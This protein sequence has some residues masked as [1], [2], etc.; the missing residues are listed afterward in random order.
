VSAANALMVA[1]PP[2][3]FLPVVLNAI[4]FLLKSKSLI[5]TEAGVI[6]DVDT[7]TEN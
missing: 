1:I 6:F 5:S 4:P 3:N 7:K 2:K